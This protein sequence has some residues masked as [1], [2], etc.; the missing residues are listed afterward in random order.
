MSGHVSKSREFAKTVSQSTVKG[1][2]RTGTQKE[3]W[4][5]NVK[6]SIVQELIY[7]EKCEEQGNVERPGL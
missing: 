7:S 4:G 1:G 6:E 5:D 2:S 3:W